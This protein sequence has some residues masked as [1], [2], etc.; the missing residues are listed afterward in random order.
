[1]T[2]GEVI[3]MLKMIFEYLSK[4]LGD[5]FAAKDESAESEDVAA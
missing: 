1:M 4:I 5:L 3:E 2:I